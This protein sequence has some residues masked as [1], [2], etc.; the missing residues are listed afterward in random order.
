MTLT[1]RSHWEPFSDQRRVLIVD[2]QRDGSRAYAKPLVFEKA[3]P[4]S[5]VREATIE[6]GDEFLQAVLNHAWEI[7]LRPAGFNDTTQQ[8]AAI[9]DHLSDMRALVFKTKP[10]GVQS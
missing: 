2:L 1:V 5:Y 3:E 6:D 4:G 8:V 9:K 7:G 10:G